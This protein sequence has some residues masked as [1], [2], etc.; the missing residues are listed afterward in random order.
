MADKTY[1][2]R[3]EL[4]DGTAQ[5]LDFVVPQGEKGEKG[6]RGEALTFDKLTAEQKASLKG[7][8]GDDYVITESDK[9]EIVDSVLEAL[10]EW[11]GGDY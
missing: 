10:P 3:F 1:R 6:D 8:K 4:S 11:T 9:R 5:T 2:L 7:E